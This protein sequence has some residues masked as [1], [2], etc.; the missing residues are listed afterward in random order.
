METG[1]QNVHI[2]GLAADSPAISFYS[3]KAS[4]EREGFQPCQAIV[5]TEDLAGLKMGIRM[6]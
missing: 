1:R 2:L 6:S 3:L 4:P 5:S